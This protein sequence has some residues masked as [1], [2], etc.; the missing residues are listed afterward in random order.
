MEIS[1]NQLVDKVLAGNKRSFVTLVE[2]Y[3]TQIFNLMYRYCGSSEEASDMTQDVFCRV[4]EKLDNYQEKN[5]FFSW[6]YTLALNYAR[7]W[8][9]KQRNRKI[10]LSRYADE[11]RS[12]Q[13]NVDH[14]NESIQET[15]MLL[16]ALDALSDDR[17]ELVMLRYRHDC[18]IRE[19]GDIFNLSES[20]TKMRLKRSLEELNKI[21][22]N[23]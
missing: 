6:V 8:S 12:Q 10:K 22:R 2:R 18:S 7:D 20:A 1:D 11:L 21:L 16:R 15:E 4:F 17:R 13:G 3:N 19:L 9:K 5:S 14:E 23:S